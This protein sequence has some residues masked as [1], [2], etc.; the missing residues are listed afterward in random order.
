MRHQDKKVGSGKNKEHEENENDIRK[1]RKG[2]L[3]W[4]NK[5]T[6][7]KDKRLISVGSF[8][9]AVAIAFY[10]LVEFRVY[11]ERRI[12]QHV[13]KSGRGRFYI[14]SRNLP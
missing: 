5:R 10:M 14:V 6:S 8:I 13:D 12:R 2:K 4:R 1:I 3:L 9:E 11:F 7:E